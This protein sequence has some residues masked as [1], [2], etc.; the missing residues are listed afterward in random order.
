MSLSLN[1]K[2]NFINIMKFSEYDAIY[3]ITDKDY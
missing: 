2:I 3:D 1:R